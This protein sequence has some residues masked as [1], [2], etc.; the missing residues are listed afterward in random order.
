MH[1]NEPA[2]RSRKSHG[3]REFARAVSATRLTP[4]PSRG[5]VQ[6]SP[7]RRISTT[8]PC[9]DATTFLLLQGAFGFL[10]PLA[11]WAILIDRDDAGSTARWCGGGALGGLAVM[12]AGLG[13]TA[14]ARFVAPGVVA[15]AAVGALLQAAALWRACGRGTPGP[16]QAS[17]LTAM[18]VAVSFAAVHHRHDPAGLAIQLAGLGALS[19]SALGLFRHERS[20]SAALIGAGSVLLLLACAARAVQV[21]EWP[22][23]AGSSPD[24]TDGACWPPPRCSAACWGT[25]AMS[26][27]RG[28]DRGRPRG[29]A[30]SNWRRSTHGC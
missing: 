24:A 28:S 29:A 8:M 26:A 4:C 20:P 30:R 9:P 22:A 5:P 17:S 3:P 23:P 6:P 10:L 15:L 18:V 27:W 19:W 13:P 1:E 2:L 7:G 25:W 11:A 12:L 16:A 14:A 21:V